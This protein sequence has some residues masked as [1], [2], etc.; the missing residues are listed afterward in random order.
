MRDK[1]YASMLDIFNSIAS[2]F[3]FVPVDNERAAD[4]AD[5]A[6]RTQTPSQVH[7]DLISGVQAALA[8]SSLV[9]V[10]GSLFLAGEA[11]DLLQKNA[12]LV[13]CDPYHIL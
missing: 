7:P 2:K 6:P 3:H 4:P 12:S 5:F 10:A 8:G 11:L 1:E 9:L 13:A